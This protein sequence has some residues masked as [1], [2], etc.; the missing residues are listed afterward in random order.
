MDKADQRFP[1]RKYRD[2]PWKVA[3]N[4]GNYCLWLAREKVLP[5]FTEY[6]SSLPWVSWTEQD[7]E[8]FAAIVA[9]AVPAFCVVREAP[10]L[11]RDPLLLVFGKLRS[12]YDLHLCSQVCKHW[13]RVSKLPELRPWN[14]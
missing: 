9:P 10:F 11:F 6:L 12:F 5:E 1:L 4:D 8:E 7:K 2:Q 14:A 13:L 3:A